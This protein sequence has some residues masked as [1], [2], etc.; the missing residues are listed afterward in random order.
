M[1]HLFQGRIT[2]AAPLNIHW[3]WTPPDGFFDLVASRAVYSLSFETASVR[4]ALLLI[5]S[6][7]SS[8]RNGSRRHAPYVPDIAALHCSIELKLQSRLEL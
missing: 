8:L 5:G 6:M 7:L 3:R 4:F 2:F 1:G